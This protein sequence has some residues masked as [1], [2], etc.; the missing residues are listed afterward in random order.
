[1]ADE[2]PRHSLSEKSG[3][4]IEEKRSDRKAEADARSQVERPTTDE[5]S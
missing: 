1:M 3:T 4:S 5:K 2:S